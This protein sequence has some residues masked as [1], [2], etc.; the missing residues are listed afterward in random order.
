MMQLK[1]EK[2]L[3]KLLATCKH[4]SILFPP[5]I[6]YNFFKINQ[7]STF[8]KEFILK[9]QYSIPFIDY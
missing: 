2:Y 6:R 4:H 1:L 8:Q 9:I 7:I 3:L 5:I